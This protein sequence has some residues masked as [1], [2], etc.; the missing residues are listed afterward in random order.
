[1]MLPTDDDY[2]YYLAWINYEEGEYDRKIRQLTR[3]INEWNNKS[4]RSK[5]GFFDPVIATERA[6][7]LQPGAKLD[8]ITP[9]PFNISAYAID[10][11]VLPGREE[12]VHGRP[13]SV[14]NV[15]VG[16]ELVYV[17]NLWNLPCAPLPAFLPA[18][19]PN[20]RLWVKEIAVKSSFEYNDYL[21]ENGDHSVTDWLHATTL[22]TYITKD[23]LRIAPSGRDQF[24]A[25]AYA[26]DT[27]MSGR[28]EQLHGDPVAITNVHVGTELVYTGPNEHW[29][30]A[31]DPLPAFQPDTTLKVKGGQLQTCRPAACSG[32]QVI[33]GT[34]T[35]ACTEVEAITSSV[36]LYDDLDCTANGCDL[37]AHTSQLVDPYV[38]PN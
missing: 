9:N 8:M 11:A 1:M 21:L 14:T 15:H 36:N 29:L 37:E 18:F 27:S 25:S 26:I 6:R 38:R 3:W 30:F 24:N 19:E 28:H 35:Q 32:A 20:T 16:T 7:S 4:Q 17:G 33:A 2:Q 10:T 23:V 12:Q 13:L 22:C 34:C 31:Y 5:M